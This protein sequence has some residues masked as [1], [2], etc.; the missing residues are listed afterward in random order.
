MIIVAI[1]LI[2]ISVSIYFYINRGETVY[3]QVIKDNEQLDPGMI[4]WEN[5]KNSDKGIHIY[6]LDNANPYEILFYYNK[7]LGKNLYTTSNLKAKIYK[8]VLRLDID[9]QPATNDNYVNDK[10]T[11][12]FIIKEKPKDMEV[13]I[14]GKKEEFKLEKGNNKISK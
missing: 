13:Y 14:N 1:C 12:Y 10:I 11:A 9:E 6:S 4:K 3:F 8:G 7:N 2:G 5:D